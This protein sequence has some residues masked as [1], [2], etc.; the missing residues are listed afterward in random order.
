MSSLNKAMQTMKYDKRLLDLNLRAGLIS[1]D[2]YNQHLKQL[3]DLEANSEIIN[4]EDNSS[5]EP[6]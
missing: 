3:E 4:L 6:N 5:N 1:Q 2:D